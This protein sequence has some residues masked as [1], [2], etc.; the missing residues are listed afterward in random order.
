MA[1]CLG[2]LIET[3]DLT[4]DVWVGRGAAMMAFSLI[5]LALRLV[6]V[7]AHCVVEQ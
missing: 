5:A 1:V 4:S 6:S 3:P 7:F 2:K